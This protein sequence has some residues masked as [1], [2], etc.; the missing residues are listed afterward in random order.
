MPSGY[1]RRPPDWLR[2]NDPLRCFDLDRAGR[3]RG[4]GMCRRI[5]VS[6]RIAGKAK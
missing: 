3:G 2:S 4:D 5:L 6:E 1:G